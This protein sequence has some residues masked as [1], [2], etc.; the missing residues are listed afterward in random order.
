MSGLE[1]VLP[2]A[3]TLCWEEELG[4]P[5]FAQ[6]QA[7]RQRFSL[8]RPGSSHNAAAAEESECGAGQHFSS[9]F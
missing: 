4:A 1:Q 5:P 9:C 8:H 3:E 2:E 7:G 6:P